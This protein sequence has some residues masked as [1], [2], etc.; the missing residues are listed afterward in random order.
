MF[1]WDVAAASTI[2]R[3]P[4]HTAKVNTVAFSADSA[5]LASGS[6]DATVALWDCRS[7]SKRPIQTLRHAKDSVSSVK[8]YGSD[9]VVGSVDGYTRIFDVRNAQLTSNLIGHPVTSVTQSRDGQS[10][11]VSS[12]DSCIRLMDTVDGKL[13]QKYKGHANEQY[14]FSSCLAHDD[15]LVL[16]SSEDG[17]IY[18]WD[19]VSGEIV[20]RVSSPTKYKHDGAML[21]TAFA[22]AVSRDGNTFATSTLDGSVELWQFT[23]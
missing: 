19:F 22:L 16:S 14:R 7:G 11:L 3:F 10:L 18:I 1:L 21:N 15:S 9:I 2:S 12:L 13:L 23:A 6:D 17:Y 5:V 8:I 20:H 4:G